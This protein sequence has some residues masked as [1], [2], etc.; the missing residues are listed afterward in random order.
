MKTCYLCHRA[1]P[2]VVINPDHVPPQSIFGDPKP[3][4]LIQ[5]DCCRQCNGDFSQ[6]DRKV[7]NLLAMCIGDSTDKQKVFPKTLNDLKNAE[8]KFAKRLAAGFRQTVIRIYDKNSVAL[9]IDLSDDEI[10][11]LNRFLVR[12]VK[13]LLRHYYPSYDYRSDE[14]DAHPIS[15]DGEFLSKLREYK[16]PFSYDKRGVD[17]FQCLRFVHEEE[18][19]GMW[20]LIFFNGS[21]F[22]VSHGHPES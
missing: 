21:I 20:I 13:G 4:N 1:E 22:W 8:W 6:I 11:I 12:V 7:K 15:Y 2:E 10:D 16:V 19:V 3:R 14:F 9:A 17:A 18:G 5:V